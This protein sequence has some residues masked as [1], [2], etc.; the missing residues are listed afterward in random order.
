MFMPPTALAIEIWSEDSD[1]GGVRGA[2]CEVT[3]AFWMTEAEGR[4]FDLPIVL[5]MSL[6][7]VVTMGDM[8]GT[9]DERTEDSSLSLPLRNDGGRDEGPE[10]SEESSSLKSPFFIRRNSAADPSGIPGLDDISDRCSSSSNA[11]ALVFFF[12]LTGFDGR[13]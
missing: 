11:L 5:G 12:L 8:G 13:S 1:S 9:G 3:T 4:L 6:G 10:A 2:T 7:A